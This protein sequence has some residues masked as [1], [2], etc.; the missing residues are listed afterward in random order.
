MPNVAFKPPLGQLT[1]VLEE[2]LA[3][4]T[5]LPPEVRYTVRETHTCY[6]PLFPFGTFPEP[7]WFNPDLGFVVLGVQIQCG[8]PTLS[9]LQ[10][11]ISIYSPVPE[12]LDSKGPFA[13]LRRSP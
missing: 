9:R 2:K 3:G 12:E 11:S 8:R 7:F 5:K 1:G 4:C 6:N 10:Y 13:S